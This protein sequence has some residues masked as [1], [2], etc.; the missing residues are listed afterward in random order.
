MSDLFGTLNMGQ[1]AL[2]AQRQGVEV[3]GHNMANVNSAGYTRQRVVLQTT[4]TQQSSIGSQGTGVSA[5]A[6][7]QIRN[8]LLDG[9]IQGEISISGSLSAQQQA[10]QQ[11]Q[12]GLGLVIDRQ[13]TS[14][15]STDGLLG[16]YSLTDGISNLFSSFQNLS[17]Q[18]TST[19]ARQSLIQSAQTLARQFNL[20]SQRLEGL[21]TDL[22]ESV[23]ADVKNVNTLLSDI[24]GLNS[25]IAD[26]E[27]GGAGTANDLR[28]TRQQKLEDLAKLVK[29]DAAE[30]TNGTVTV[31]VSGTTVVE[32]GQVKDTLEAY[33][34]GGGQYLVR[35]QSSGAPLAL[36]GGSLHGTIDARDGALAD[37]QSRL[38]SL[39]GA[40][41]SEINKVHAA[42]YSLSNTTGADFFTGADA[43]TIQ[44]N[45]A[46][47]NNAS[48]VQAS[49]VSGAQSDNQTALALARLASQSI[50]SL[51]DATFSGHFGQTIGNL[52]QS[53][54]NVN[55]QVSDQQSMEDM[56][57]AQREST[58]GVSLDEEMTNLIKFQKA[59]EASAKLVN[60]VD[61]MLTTVLSLKQ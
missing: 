29:F 8:T 38:N 28:D 15:T 20:A 26:L 45:Q 11:A 14:S 37:T 36:T 4:T 22:N 16:S 21:K 10:L 46:L 34:A 12:S 44:V 40:M 61:Q 41:I 54:S 6:I 49:G 2:Q 60:T 23:K 48:L 18:A 9:Q 33:D 58:S 13:T 1:R 31:S 43:A 42:G 3:T 55:N 51:G 25:K 59:F 24:A 52:A 30:Q 7:Q 17:A 27:A 53:L 35:A 57:K 47:V 50:A 56:L 32:G 5:V 39:A 19:D